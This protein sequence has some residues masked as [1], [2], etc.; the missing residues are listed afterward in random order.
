MGI[1]GERDHG[2]ERKDETSAGERDE[3]VVH[4]VTTTIAPEQPDAS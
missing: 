1:G 3:Y 2:Y 4:H